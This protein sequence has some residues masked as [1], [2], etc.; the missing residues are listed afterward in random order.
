MC[1][2]FGEGESWGPFRD[3]TELKFVLKSEISTG[4]LW[5]CINYDTVMNIDADDR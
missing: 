5:Q 4:Y 1:M 3:V 2:V